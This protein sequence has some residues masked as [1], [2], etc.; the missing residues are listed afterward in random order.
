MDLIDL[1]E[2]IINAEVFN[3]LSVTMGNPQFAPSTSEPSAHHDTVV[4]VPS[5]T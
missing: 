3:S 4:E 1:G 5:V 2:D